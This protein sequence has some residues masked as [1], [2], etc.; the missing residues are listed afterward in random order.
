MTQIRRERFST[1]D[2]AWLHMDE[3]TSMAMITGVL[4]FDAPLDFERLQATL[5]H[6]LLRHERFRQRVVE[7][8]LGIGLPNWETDPHFHLRA[9]LHR[10][11]LPAPG[12][13]AALQEL[14]GD[15]MSTPL[16]FTK[17]LWQIH[18]VENYGAGCALIVRLHHCISDGL[19]LV[20]VLL[21]L[22]DKDADAPWPEAQEEPRRAWGPLAALFR[23]A[24]RT[25]RAT[26]ALVSEGR[27]ILLDRERLIDLARLGANSAYE[28]GKLVLT[29]PDERTVFKG[30]LGVAKRVAWSAPMAL[31]A[32]KAIGKATDSTVNDV[33][34]SAVTGALRR[35]LQGRDQ[36]V[37]GLNVRAMVPVN[38][39]PL[40][41]MT[42]LGNRFGLVLLS[43]P[44][45]VEKPRQ[46]LEVLKRR[47]RALKQSPEAAVAFG[48]LGALGLA[49]AELANRLTRFFG[50][51][52]TA[53]MT[54]VP[55]PRELIYLA[56]QPLRQMIFWV[57]APGRL[58]LGVSIFS[59]AGT[60]VVGVAT[61]AR[62]VPDPE[63]LVAGFHAELEQMQGWIQKTGRAP[64]PK[65]TK[66]RAPKPRAAQ[67]QAGLCLAR[68]R[69][70]EPCR[71]K[72]RPG[73]A[74]CHIHRNA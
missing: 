39:R 41:E 14:A 64:Q 36:T 69:A 25:L 50:A 4:V 11:A 46:R 56:G 6:R 45:G 2:A 66:T 55:G 19:S 16:D 74:T 43:L 10:V 61:D 15:L 34:L 70:G 67:E 28:A 3:P 21:S 37:D 35:Y 60:V 42:D 44:V 54:N 58:G 38:L 29:L 52:A 9:H 71:N 31:P 8:P 17:P 59:Y 40:E 5:L 20:Q 18:L 73:Q 48:I 47:M 1:V 22:T 72:A 65:K 7:A 63:T 49:P 30:R 13:Q 26:R 33:L 27:D 53:V 32:V 24:L 68:T 23:P 12:G 57:P 62:R 51:K